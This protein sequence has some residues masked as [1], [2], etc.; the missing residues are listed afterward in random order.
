MASSSKK[1]IKSIVE[2][3][4]P[5]WQTISLA[6]DASTV[7]NK[8]AAPA[9]QIGKDAGELRTKYRQRKAVPDAIETPESDVRFVRIRGTAPTDVEV[10]AKTVVVDVKV[11][12]VRGVQG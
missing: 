6:S 12:K 5:G 7:R 3:A 11:G 2:D 4:M 1:T 9:E 10:G 8:D